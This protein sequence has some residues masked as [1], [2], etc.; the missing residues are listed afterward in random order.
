MTYSRFQSDKYTRIEN[1]SYV[2]QQMKYVI[3]GS[4]GKSKKICEDCIFA[5]WDPCSWGTKP[6]SAM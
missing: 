2:D 6:F 1:V 5:W 3:S 4:K